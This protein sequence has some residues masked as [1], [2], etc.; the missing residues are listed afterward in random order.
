VLRDTADDATAAG[1]DACSILL[2][3]PLHL[4][5]FFRIKQ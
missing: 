2:S 5:T 1:G 3:P 4:S